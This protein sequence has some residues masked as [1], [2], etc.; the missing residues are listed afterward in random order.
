MGALPYCLLPTPYCLPLCILPRKPAQHQRDPPRIAGIERMSRERT[1]GKNRGRIVAPQDAMRR[2]DPEPGAHR[3]PGK[4]IAERIMHALMTAEMRIHVEG[5]GAASRP[6][7]VD[8]HV[9]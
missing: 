8:P 4:A 3:H 9:R 1:I 7:I 5:P 2:L 6:H